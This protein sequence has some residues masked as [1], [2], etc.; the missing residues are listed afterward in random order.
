MDMLT[1]SYHRLVH[2]PTWMPPFRSY[3]PQRKLSHSSARFSG[4]VSSRQTTKSALST[5]SRHDSLF[6]FLVSALRSCDH[7]FRFSV[8]STPM[9]FRATFVPYSVSN[10]ESKRMLQ[11]P[12]SCMGI[13]S[14]SPTIACKFLKISRSV[15]TGRFSASSTSNQS[16][17]RQ[18]NE[19]PAASASPC[20]RNEN[21]ATYRTARGAIQRCA[22]TLGA[23]PSYNPAICGANPEVRL[24]GFW[25][26]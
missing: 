20:E 25:K 1:L 19:H 4:E 26:E 13:W 10:L 23:S 15:K 14:A 9:A 21:A 24:R 8:E 16:A 11:A 22:E 5:T 17:G 2:V 12:T 18:I 3:V 7:T 6:L